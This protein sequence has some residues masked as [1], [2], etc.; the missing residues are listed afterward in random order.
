[1]NITIRNTK[2]VLDDIKRASS[3][4]DLQLA[5]SAN[6]ALSRV[7]NSTPVDTGAAKAAWRLERRGKSFRLSNDKEY[8]DALN[9]GS[10]KQAP[11]NFI[12]IALLSD[13]T[14]RSNGT[15]VLPQN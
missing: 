3:S 9:N 7:A 11:S 5:K 8:I 14:L 13:S 10:S 12:E 6:A 1:M 15:I 4:I 2:S